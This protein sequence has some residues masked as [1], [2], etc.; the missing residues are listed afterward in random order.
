MPARRSIRPRNVPG[1]K[2]TVL[3]DPTTS[4]A[5]GNV[6]SA[7]SQLQG[8]PQ[9][10]PPIQANLVVGSN[11]VKHGLNRAP[12]WV[13]VTPSVADATFAWALNPQNPHPELQLLIDV[14]GVAQPGAL[15]LVC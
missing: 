9:F 6:A 2:S 14:V 12:A 1:M 13:G 11:T 10:S 7:V 8:Q 4:R 5:V 3:S 15:I